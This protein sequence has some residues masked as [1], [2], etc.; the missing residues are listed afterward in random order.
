MFL[1]FDRFSND[2]VRDL[3]RNSVAIL[4]SLS[5][6]FINGFNY[7]YDNDEFFLNDFSFFKKCK[8]RSNF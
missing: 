7:L 5:P 2:F 6:G 3:F 8:N 4:K 1:L